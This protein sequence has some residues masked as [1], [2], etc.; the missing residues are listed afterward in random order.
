[1]CAFCNPD[2][3][4]EGGSCNPALCNPDT[5]PGCCDTNGMCQPGSDKGAC[6]FNGNQCA[7][8]PA[9]TVCNGGTCSGFGCGP[10]TCPDGCCDS[11][12][13][14]QTGFGGNGGTC[15]CAATCQ[16]CCDAAGGCRAGTVTSECG[17]GGAS[18]ADCT[19]L[20]QTCDTNV[21]PVTCDQSCPSPY[22]GCAPGTTTP[23]PQ[24]AP[25]ACR[26]GDL[27]DAA[28]ACAAGAQTAGCQAFFNGEFGVNPSCASCL[29]Q[30]DV[31]F[32][33]R[34][35]IYLCAA[36]LVSA[37][38]NGQTG[39]ANDCISTTCQQ[40][41]GDPTACESTAI[42]GECSMLVN[43]GDTCVTGT[44]AANALCGQASYPN[45]GSW[46]SGVGKHYC[47]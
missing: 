27:T 9:P 14:C 28:M 39:C 20:G 41:A 32:V 4:C 29:Q 24:S 35:G 34:D 5:C 26:A 17:S 47:G 37:S 11:N 40:C 42:A 16:G 22:A 2:T 23:L 46:L 13:A 31:D 12:G 30:F 33:T 8:C 3:L 18:C 38:C 25:G 44:T 36:P 43:D 19:P 45:F 21:S 15:P 7:S 10:M 6:G 1:M